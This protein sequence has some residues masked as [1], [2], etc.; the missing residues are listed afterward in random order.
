MSYLK[1]VRQCLTV[2]Y[3]KD[4]QQKKLS[5]WNLHHMNKE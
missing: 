1:S 2:A 3:F 5:K 4:F